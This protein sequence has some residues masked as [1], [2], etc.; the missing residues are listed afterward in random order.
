MSARFTFI[1][2]GLYRHWLSDA[3]GRNSG[4]VVL[5]IYSSKQSNPREVKLLQGG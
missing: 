5:R 2:A 3:K 1:L 4:E